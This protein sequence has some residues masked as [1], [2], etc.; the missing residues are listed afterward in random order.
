MKQLIPAVILSLVMLPAAFAQESKTSSGDRNKM[1]EMQE[2]MAKMHQDAAECLKS[3]KSVDTCQSE[4]MK[5]CAMGKSHC[6][7]MSKMMT[8]DMSMMEGMHGK[9]KKKDKM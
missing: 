9:G 1:I 6:Q 4:M 5:R 8:G 2:K 7:M 3:E